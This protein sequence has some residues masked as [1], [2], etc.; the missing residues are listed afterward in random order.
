[1][2]S[3]FWAV[4]GFLTLIRFFSEL[5]H[6]GFRQ[7]LVTDVNFANFGHTR[8]LFPHS[9][10]FYLVPCIIGAY[11]VA[12]LLL[13]LRSKGVEGIFFRAPVALFVPF[14]C[15]NE[16]SIEENISRSP[17]GGDAERIFCAFF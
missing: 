17:Q 2:V 16:D 6:I 1:M 4:Q 5:T 9:V 13:F 8:W 15:N 10:T 3:S 7:C 14:F 11:V 12:K